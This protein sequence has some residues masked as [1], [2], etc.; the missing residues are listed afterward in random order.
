VTS[1]GQNPTL[2]QFLRSFGAVKDNLAK[3]LEEFEGTSDEKVQILFTA[4]S[5][6]ESI[7]N[8][9]AYESQLTEA[10]AL[11]LE[12]FGKNPWRS[13]FRAAVVDRRNHGLSLIFATQL[14][15]RIMST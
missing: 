9:C 1:C 14:K 3:T 12:K 4:H 15:G 10:C 7:A 5:I 2:L 13:F 8:R 11:V 6:P